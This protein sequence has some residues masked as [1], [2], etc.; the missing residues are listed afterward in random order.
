MHHFFKWAF[1]KLPNVCVHIDFGKR[2]LPPEF[3]IHCDRA[4]L[5]FNITG[6]E[7]EL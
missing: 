6:R 2:V 4:A 5:L 1:K 7:L 3:E